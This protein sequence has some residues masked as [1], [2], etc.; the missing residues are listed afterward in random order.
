[1]TSIT[2]VIPT[3]NGALYVMDAIN[4]VCIQ[5]FA[6]WR[7]LVIDDASQDETVDLAEAIAE[8]D[9]RIEVRRNDSNIGLY[10]SLERTIAEIVTPFTIILMQDDVLLSHHMENF[11]EIATVHPQSV[12]FWADIDLVD[13]NGSLVRRGLR[14]DRIHVTQP[15]CAAVRRAFDRGCYWT[16][17][18][19]FS[20][21]A[22]LKRLPFRSDLRHAADFE[23]LVKTLA[24]APICYVFDTFTRIR[25]HDGQL[26]RAYNRSARDLSDMMAIYKEASGRKVF[27][28]PESRAIYRRLKR[29]QARRV[30]SQLR[31]FDFPAAARAIGLFAT[32]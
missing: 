5:S 23:L 29:G 12:M 32:T 16:I 21:T 10:A 3:Y 20:R 6:D 18:G 1:M 8:T 11:A 24:E 7:L 25:L 17:S 26:S 22:H 9:P 28:A 30:F 4:S 2:V 19:S 27:S 31:R 14:G 13:Q 15:S